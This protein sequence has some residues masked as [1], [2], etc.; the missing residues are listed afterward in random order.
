MDQFGG[1]EILSTKRHVF[2]I[3]ARS[4]L[5][6]RPAGKRQR[7]LHQFLK[8]LSDNHAVNR[9]PVA[10]P[11]SNHQ[12]FI[13]HNLYLSVDQGHQRLMQVPIIGELKRRP[14]LNG[15]LCFQ[16]PACLPFYHY[17]DRGLSARLPYQYPSFL[18]NRPVQLRISK[19]SMIRQ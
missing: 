15:L 3:K 8:M 12:A 4:W 13:A 17:P 14:T 2:R 19:K 1:A 5:R 6:K 9:L 10:F 16:F 11:I 7:P 18:P